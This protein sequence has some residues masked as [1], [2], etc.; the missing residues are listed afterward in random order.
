[1]P[2]VFKI[3]QALLAVIV[4]VSCG[5]NDDSNNGGSEATD[6]AA[7]PLP[8]EP[9]VTE[10]TGADADIPLDSI[11]LVDPKL[12]SEG[13]N[14]EWQGEVFNELAMGQ[15]KSLGKK[16]E[17]PEQ[18]TAE[19]LEGIVLKGAQSAALVPA[20]LQPAFQD[21]AF[22]VRGSTGPA[23]DAPP[24]AIHAALA[25]LVAPFDPATGLRSEFKIFTVQLSA[26][27][28]PECDAYFQSC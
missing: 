23:T 27:G 11:G 22:S 16:L 28:E 5:G 15:L 25:Q 3:L 13:S 17:H 14:G 20:D 4:V 21:S 9:V 26:D 1:M 19:G 10:P 2:R 12:H 6:K 18:I 24:I 7:T 8:A